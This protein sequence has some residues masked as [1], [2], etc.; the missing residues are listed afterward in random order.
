MTAINFTNRKFGVEIECVG[1]TIEEIKKLFRDNEIPVTESLENYTK[2][3]VKGDG[4]IKGIY[5]NE[6]T[7]CVNCSGRGNIPSRNYG[8]CTCSSCM[9]EQA[10][11]QM[12]TSGTMRCSYCN[13]TGARTRKICKGAEVVSPILSGPEGLKHLYNVVTLMKNNG[14]SANKSC[15]LHVHVFAKDHKKSR[16]LNVFHRYSKFE[17]TIDKW[18]SFDRRD[19]KNRYCH[20]TKN[21]DVLDNISVDDILDEMGGRLSFEQQITALYNAIVNKKT[22]TPSEK[23]VTEKI[24]DNYFDSERYCKV[25]LSA[26]Q[27]L[28]TVEFRHHHGIVD[29]D[30]IKNWAMFCVQFFEQSIK[31]DQPD[32][33]S[34]FI[35]V[36]RS[37]REYF[38]DEAF[39]EP[40][41]KKKKPTKKRAA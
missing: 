40:K 26:Y 19:N 24:T 9:T 6:S 14:I 35:G 23:K 21:N 12:N 11:R 8:G 29:P 32:R 36:N 16:V 10:R 1:K 31:E 22:S 7:P 39:E 25:N 28:G 38:N 27:D 20:S 37:V 3:S 41:K 2:W 33:D 4:S 18:I 30:R 34:L 17:K 5:V 15:G 13:G